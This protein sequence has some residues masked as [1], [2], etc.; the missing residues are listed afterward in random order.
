MTRSLHRVAQLRFYFALPRLL[1]KLCG[2]SGIRSESNGWETHLA[3]LLVFVMSELVAMEAFARNT[4]GWKRAAVLLVCGF[5]LW[6]FWPAVIFINSLVIRLVRA[7]GWFERT[8]DGYVQSV[9]IGVLTT[10]FAWRLIS[11]GP[12]IQFIAMIWMVAI[13]ANLNAAIVL[14]LLH[15]NRGGA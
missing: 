9:L 2:G 7:F 10:L 8:P 11:A 4:G 5:A 13:V 1:A 12:A 15:A 3:G 6:I 14:A